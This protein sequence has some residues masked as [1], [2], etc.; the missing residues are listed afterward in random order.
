MVIYTNMNLE[1][2]LGICIGDS[3]ISKIY[4]RSK[5]HFISWEHSEK[6]YDYAIWKAKQLGISY[7]VYER[8]R[9]DIR[10]K[11]IYK[12][13]IIYSKQIDFKNYR[14]LF[15]PEGKKEISLDVLLKL[16]EQDIAIW[17]CDDGNLYYNG[18][19]C[20]LTLA[21]DKYRDKNELIINYFK[22]RW[23]LNFK[24]TQTRIRL[25]SNIEVKKFETM[26]KDY[27]PPMME[28]KTLEFNKKKYYERKKI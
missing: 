26:F 6:Q 18:N 11:N 15:Y 27:Y 14:E 4:G 12:S 24:K 19:N 13:V 5:T 2:I 28:Y 7:G 16:K 20:H 8:S 1:F 10:T 17:F 9:L 3:H 22:E 23:G 25:T 21:T